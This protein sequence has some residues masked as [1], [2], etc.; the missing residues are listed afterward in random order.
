MGNSLKISHENGIYKPSTI[1]KLQNEIEFV[2]WKLFS[3]YFQ[4][5]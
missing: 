5:F 3:V 2:S 1:T 4:I